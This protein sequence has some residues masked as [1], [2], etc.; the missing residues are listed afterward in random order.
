[1]GATGITNTTNFAAIEIGLGHGPEL[2]GVLASLQGAG[3]VAGGLTAGALV[4]RLGERTLAAVGVALI[5]LGVATTV[6]T[7]LV[8]MCV[9]LVVAGVGVSWTVV[10]FVTLRQRLTPATLQGRV[11]AASNMVINVPQLTAALAAAGLIL[12][13]DYRILIGFTVVVIL[14]AAASIALRRAEQEVPA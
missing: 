7:S 13:V 8:V 14:G 1:V 2:L 3:A 5:G 4:T 12:V 9:G 10:A 11:S 6:G